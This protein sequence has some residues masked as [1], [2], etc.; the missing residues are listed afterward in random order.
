MIS[1]T[2]WFDKSY[3]VLGLKLQAEECVMKLSGDPGAILLLIRIPAV[4]ALMALSAFSVAGHPRE[5]HFRIPLEASGLKIFLR[6]L[7]PANRRPVKEGRVVL[8]LHGGT[9]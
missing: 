2:S 4:I 7:P 9:L 8:I 5:E 3:I 6:H 1:E